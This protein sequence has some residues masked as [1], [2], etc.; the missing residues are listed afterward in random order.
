[1]YQYSV[2]W[3]ISLNFEVTQKTVR[4]DIYSGDKKNYRYGQKGNI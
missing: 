3:K 2:T 4:R 1:M